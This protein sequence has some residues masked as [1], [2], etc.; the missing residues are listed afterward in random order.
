ML[1]LPRP[2]AL[3]ASRGVMGPGPSSRR[4]PRSHIGSPSEAGAS[5][6]RLRALGGSWAPCSG[7]CVPSCQ[8]GLLISSQ[9][10]L[11]EGTPSLGDRG[12]TPHRRS[13]V[14]RLQAHA[15]SGRW[16]TR[17]EFW[18]MRGVDGT[19]G[20]GRP[21]QPSHQG[22]PALEHPVPSPKAQ[23]TSSFPTAFPAW[24]DPDLS[25]EGTRPP[26]E[27]RPRTSRSPRGDASA[28]ASLSSRLHVR[29]PRELA[30]SEGASAVASRSPALRPRQ[31]RLAFEPLLPRDR[32]KWVHFEVGKLGAVSGEGGEL[33]PL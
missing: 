5:L 10:A 28:A 32:V 31:G 33:A 11:T 8:A 3:V 12:A 9:A 26:R 27:P 23:A 18:D 19:R 30:P 4:R 17:R 14:A 20:C 16:D 7:G 1:T 25:A 21:R 24:Q 29:C 6:P 22:V 13:S 15:A 2:P